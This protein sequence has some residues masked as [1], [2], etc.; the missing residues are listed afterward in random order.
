MD[1]LGGPTIRDPPGGKTPAYNMTVFTYQ[2]STDASLEHNVADGVFLPASS[3]IVFQAGQQ[4]GHAVT[5]MMLGSTR[6]GKIARIRG[7]VVIVRWHAQSAG[8]LLDRILESLTFTATGGKQTLQQLPAGGGSSGTHRS[9]QKSSLSFF[10]SARYLGSSRTGSQVAAARV[11]I[12]HPERRSYASSYSLNPS[13]RSPSAIRTC[14]S[15]MG[16]R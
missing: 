4:Q 9:S 10:S 13:S 1:V 3:D 14:P 15:Y 5:W 8:S 16:E 6:T 11:N 7:R 12:S 2:P